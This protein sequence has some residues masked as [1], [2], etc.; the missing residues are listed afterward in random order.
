MRLEFKD[1]IDRHKGK[2]AIIVAHGPSSNKYLDKLPELQKRGYVVI[3]INDWYFFHPHTIPKYV[4]IANNVYTIKNKYQIMNKYDSVIVYADSVDRT[5]KS[6]VDSH[7]KCDYLPYSQRHF[8]HNNGRLTLQE[9]LLQYTSHDRHYGSG[10]TAALHQIALGI[11]LGCNPVY[12]IGM[13]LDYRLGFAKNS[14][15]KSSSSF[16]VHIGALSDYRERILKS[17]A[18]IRDSANNIGTDVINLNTESNYDTVPTEVI[19]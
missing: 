17:L 1:I 10:D 16:G 14:G 7:L 3:G 5:P 18:V 4:I 9:E 15:G 19:A 11:L 13:D 12:F 8:G 6:F 2:P